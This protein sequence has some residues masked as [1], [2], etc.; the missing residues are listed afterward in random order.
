MWYLLIN[1]HRGIAY[2]KTMRENL[3]RVLSLSS[4]YSSSDKCYS[5]MRKCGLT[6]S[7]ASF[8]LKNSDKHDYINDIDVSRLLNH[9]FKYTRSGL[10]GFI[11][12]LFTQSLK[13]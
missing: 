12:S 6:T 7:L 3:L 9:P 8:G 4:C 5:L 1:D 2:F 13:D 10:S 11:T